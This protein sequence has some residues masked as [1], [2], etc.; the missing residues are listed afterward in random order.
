MLTIFDKKL[1]CV[2]EK[3][4]MISCVQLLFQKEKLQCKSTSGI[5]YMYQSLK[6][7]KLLLIHITNTVETYINAFIRP[8]PE[9]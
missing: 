8:H 9:S 3:W 6:H 4:F 7:K 1:M 2:H 5:I